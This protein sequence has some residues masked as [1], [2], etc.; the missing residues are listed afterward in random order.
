M[1]WG[2]IN[3]GPIRARP[4]T[5]KC[6]TSSNANGPC[7][8]EPVRLEVAIPCVH[9]DDFLKRTLPYTVRHLTSV[10]V[11]TSPSDEATITVARAL[12]I[13]ILVTDAWSDGG[14]FNKARALNE[15]IARQDSRDNLLWLMTLDAD[16]LLPSDWS[17]HLGHLDPRG[18]YS[19]RRR[20][21]ETESEWDDFISRR[22]SLYSFPLDVPPVIDGQVWGDKPTTNPAA[23]CG[24]L[25]IWNPARGSGFTSFPEAP[26][27]A[28][29]DVEFALSYPEQLR[30][31]LPGV[32]VLHL[33]VCATNWEGRRSPRW[34]LGRL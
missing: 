31:F 22:R 3:A 24:Y 2:T 28:Q 33:S 23:L 12:G 10:T 4:S 1:N 13:K 6:A 19:A 27:A 26:S 5:D 32:D 7:S 9:Y 17:V 30:K 29:Y 8:D 11:L 21:C 25:Q 34:E 20:L 16:I 14:P 18:L 15:W